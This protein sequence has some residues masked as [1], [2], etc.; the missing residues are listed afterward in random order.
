MPNS[1]DITA[2]RKLT[3]ARCRCGACGFYF[4][5]IG[6]FD[7]HRAGPPTNRRCLSPAE[8]V[9]RGMTTNDTGFWV[10]SRMTD[11][12]LQRADFSRDRTAPLPTPRVQSSPLE[13]EARP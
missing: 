1:T 4:N 3:G 5:S 8:M 10:R 11:A 7:R 13:F 12:D 6:A 2:R 9:A